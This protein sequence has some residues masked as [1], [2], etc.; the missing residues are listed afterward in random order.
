MK[1]KSIFQLGSLAL[2]VAATSIGV[3]SAELE[4]I[5]VTA[6]KRSESLQD[7]PMSITAL[8][9]ERM[10]EAG[11]DSFSALSSHGRT[12]K[13]VIH[14]LPKGKAIT[15]NLWLHSTVYI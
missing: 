13:K 4:E 15:N 8:G 9:G 2:A 6:Q 12:L 14:T 5:T 3:Y 7:V 10:E 1:T 11:I